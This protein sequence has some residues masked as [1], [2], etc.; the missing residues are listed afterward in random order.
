ML[1]VRVYN[2]YA[3]NICTSNVYEYVYCYKQMCVYLYTC[4]LIYIRSIY[5]TY[6]IYTGILKKKAATQETHVIISRVQRQKR[7]FVTVI[8]G[9]ETVTDLKIKDVARSCG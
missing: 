1:L 8:T 4:L 3:L 2:I 5:T 9:L 6:T 7:K